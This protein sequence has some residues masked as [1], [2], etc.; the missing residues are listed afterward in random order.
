MTTPPATIAKLGKDL[1]GGNVWRVRSSKIK[2]NPA[3]TILVP[4]G[5]ANARPKPTNTGS[6]PETAIRVAGKVRL[7]INT[8][9][10]P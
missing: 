3:A 2:D 1:S 5:Y 10:N 4:R 6:N 9:K 7:K 8:P